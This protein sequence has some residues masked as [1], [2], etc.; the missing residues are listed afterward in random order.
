MAA[1]VV[2]GSG[3]LFSS[4]AAAE[5]APP[6]IVEDFSYPGAAAILARDNIKLI[7]GDGGIMYA[8]CA[9]PPV[10][11]VGVIKVY[12]TEQVG[13]DGLGQACFRVLKAAGHV[14]MEVPGVYEIRGDGRRAGT[15]HKLT[16]IV[17]TDEGQLPPV[18]VN[19][20]GST[21]VGIGADPGDPPTTLLQL[22]VTP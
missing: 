20:S 11:D 17:R 4:S 9:T 13:A 22:T 10:G 8:D 7:S 12:T 21:Q 14:E 6:S 19:P 1:G 15:G 5:D 2:A 3:A 16:A 18:T